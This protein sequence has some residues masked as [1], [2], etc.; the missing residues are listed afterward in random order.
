MI[1]NRVG[2]QQEFSI[3]DNA[4]VPA[5]KLFDMV[6]DI[7]SVLYHVRRANK[8][9]VAAVDIGL[10]LKQFSKTLVCVSTQRALG[11]KL[12]SQSTWTININTA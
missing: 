10:F 11:K 2:I 3:D 8:K 6:L 1:R 9:T 7:G 12:I 5:L 4:I